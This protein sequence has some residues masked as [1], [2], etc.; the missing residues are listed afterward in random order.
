MEKKPSKKT[1][2]KKPSLAAAKATPSAPVIAAAPAAIQPVRPAAEPVRAA[3]T[4]A[5]APVAPPTPAV[6]PAKK[7]VTTVKAKVD[8][9]FGNTLYIRGQ[10]CGLSWEKGLPLICFDAASWVWS[11]DK[12]NETIAFKLL[13]NDQVWAQ[14]EDIVVAP[15]EQVEAAPVF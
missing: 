13:V 5:P 1:A 8:V 3:A 4:P 9:G 10:G 11:T 6:K 12:A 2:S 14:G 15:G 7:P